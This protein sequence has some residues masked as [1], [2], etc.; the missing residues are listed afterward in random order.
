[1]A[2]R[3]KINWNSAMQDIRKDRA[4]PVVGFMAARS[5]EAAR[6]ARLRDEAH[7]QPFVV[8]GSYD[9]SAMMKAAHAKLLSILKASD[10]I[11]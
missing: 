8:N 11:L 9:L 1:M 10:V 7:A 2:A 4:A 3:N 6:L 5:L